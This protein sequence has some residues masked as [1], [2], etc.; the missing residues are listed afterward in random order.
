MKIKW[1]YIKMIFN[2]RTIFSLFK[3]QCFSHFIIFENGIYPIINHPVM[4]QLSL[5][6][7]ILANFYLSIMIHCLSLQVSAL[8]TLTTAEWEFQIG[9]RNPSKITLLGR[10]EV[11]LYSLSI[12]TID[13][14]DR[15][16]IKNQRRQWHPTP[17]LLPGKSLVGCSPWGC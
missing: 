3:K 15:L 1:N 2:V 17:G 10:T 11:K 14:Q 9:S 5:Q 13:S 7:H 12:K 8:V 16:A 4:M 6:L